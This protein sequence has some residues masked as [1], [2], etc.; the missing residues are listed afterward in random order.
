MTDKVI[1]LDV[2]ETLA[3][4]SENSNKYTSMRI[5][6]SGRSLPY[7][8]RVYQFE[9]ADFD[10]VGSGKMI[11]CWGIERPYVHEFITFCFNYFRYVIVWSAGKR[12]YVHMMVDILFKHHQ[13]PHLILTYDDLVTINGV[14]S[15]PLSMVSDIIGVD[16]SKIWIVD[17]KPYINFI[18]NPSNGITIPEFQPAETHEELLEDDNRL[19]QLMSWF[20]QLGEVDDVRKSDTSRIFR[21]LL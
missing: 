7:R 12:S 11:S 8:E 9:L 10:D 3:Y 4:T 14:K 16:I 5:F 18:S 17:D 13:R 2:D 20:N 21:S 6:T 1:V 15:K 19:S